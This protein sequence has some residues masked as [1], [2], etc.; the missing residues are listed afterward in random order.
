MAS[1]GLPSQG[2]RE[3]DVVLLGGTGTT[4]MR[5]VK[6]LAAAKA[7]EPHLKYAVAGRSIDRLRAVVG[8]PAV[9]LIAADTSDPAS[10]D[11]LCAR[12]KVGEKREEER[13]REKQKREEEGSACVHMCV[14]TWCVFTMYAW[15][16]EAT[17]HVFSNVGHPP[18]SVLPLS[19]LRRAAP[20]P[21][22]PS[23]LP[24]SS[25]KGGDKR[26]GAVP[27][28]RAPRRGRVCEE[29]CTLL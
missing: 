19:L 17:P 20:P 6:A 27:V 2:D 16:S 29:R 9:A 4:G 18:H 26:G 12:T 25:P 21:P 1:F 13:R 15:C 14:H 7:R 11:A 24:P 8:D 10:L 5:T 23:L 3:F 28:S 22:L